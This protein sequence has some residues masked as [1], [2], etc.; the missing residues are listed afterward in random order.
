MSPATST[1]TASKNLGSHYVETFD[2]DELKNVFQAML[3]D[4][5]NEGFDPFAAPEET[6]YQYGPKRGNNL[7]ALRRKRLVAS[8]M[9]GLPGDLA[10]RT[11]ADRFPLNRQFQEIPADKPEIH[12]EPGFEGQVH[13]YNMFD[14]V[15][16]SDVTWNPSVVMKSGDVAAMP[17]DIRH[18]GYSPKRS[19]LVVWENGDPTLPELYGSGKL[20]PYPIAF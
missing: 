16:R 6:G 4:W 9:V 11:D 1:S 13:A 2:S 14:Y 18:K 5:V 7:P 3:E 15:A 19:L 17:A 8:H 12:A 20:P 10:Y